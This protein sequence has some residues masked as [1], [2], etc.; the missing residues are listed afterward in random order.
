MKIRQAKLKDLEQLVGLRLDFAVF[1]QKY[2]PGLSAKKHD[3]NFQT[4]LYEETKEAVEK[5]SPV[6]FVAEDE[7]ELA[8]YANLFVYPDFKNK[9]FIGELFIKADR[10]NRGIAQAIIEFL[11]KWIKSHKRNMLQVAVAEKNSE[12][13]SLFKKKGFKKI[14][15]NHINLELVVS[16]D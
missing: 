6:F 13:L 1:E 7:G 3:K 16:N 15:S 12:I 14:K 9:A 11:I 8:G 2:I 4:R 10:R 5:N